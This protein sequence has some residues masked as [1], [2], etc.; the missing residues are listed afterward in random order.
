MAEAYCEPATLPDLRDAL[1]WARAE[2][3]SVTPIGEGSNLVLAGDVAGLVVRPVLS[4]V[5]TLARDATTVTLRVAAGEN[6]HALVARCLEEGYY[7]LENLALIPGTVGAAPIQNIGAYG[8]ELESFV[9]RVHALS[10][11]TGE[12]VTFAAD[13]CE[14]SY[15]DSVFKRA[16]RDALV[17]T[18]V[19]LA[20]PLQ[21]CV[22]VR[23]PA[24]AANL[25]ERAVTAPT[26]RD[27]FDA[28]VAIRSARLPN[29]VEIPNA[30]S[31]F[32]NPIVDAEAGAALKSRHPEM[33]LF[34]AGEG[35]SKLSA[36][37]LIDQCGW[38]GRRE[39]G[40]GVHEH[41]ALVL[42]H[43]GGATGAELLAFAARIQESVANTF[44]IDLE[45]EPRRYGGAP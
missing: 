1:D 44:G 18:A 9:V 36:A 6:W 27:V 17:I 45:I 21:P 28:V 14:F 35:A 38:K 29:P 30:G 39:G 23:Y 20:L 19:D 7:G 10:I 16:M 34:T 33:P 43:R 31:F 5:S 37:W 12:D 22:D 3:L 42:V 24:L 11:A 32:K 8:V 15:R 40:V 13:A 4:G 41:H 26:P 2:G 25:A